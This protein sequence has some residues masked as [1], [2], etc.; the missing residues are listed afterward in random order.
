MAIAST[1]TQE[2]VPIKEV[3]DGVIILK[4]GGLRAVLLVSSLNFAL[5]SEDNQQ[6]IIAQF[7][8]FL[9]S[10]DFSTQIFIQSRRLDIRPYIA[11]LEERYKEQT[12]DL[13]RVQTQEYINFIKK[14][15]ETINIMTKSFFIVVP[16]STPL[17]ESRGGAIG[18]FMSGKKQSSATTASEQ[19]IEEFEEARTQL[20]QR[21]SVVEQGLVRCGI[22][23]IQLG[24]EEMIELF[25]KMFNP[26]ETEKPLQ[27]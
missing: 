13:M 1:A 21:I 4:D 16:Y 20:A 17:L 18:K 7:Q 27:V 12:T 5:K 19:K 23:V 11:L 10:L 26:G 24:T 25:Y 8:N 2:F 15:T 3:R 9:N 22:R 14:F 6:A